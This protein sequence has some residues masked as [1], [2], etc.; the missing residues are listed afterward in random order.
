MRRVLA[1]MLLWIVSAAAQQIG[2][3]A[4]AED[5]QNFKITVTTRLV[6]ETVVAKDKQGN[7][8]EGLTANDFTITEDGVPQTIRFCEHQDLPET[9]IASASVPSQPE[10]IKLYRELP[11]SRISPES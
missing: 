6:V 3:N 9:P 1:T 10:N 4:P 5:N 7:T 2:Q 8:I 11:R